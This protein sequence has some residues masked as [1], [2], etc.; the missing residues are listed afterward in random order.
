MN[1]QQVHGTPEPARPGV[2]KLDENVQFTVYR[3]QVVVPEKWYHLLAFAH[4]SERRENAPE[5]N[6]T[7]CR[8]CSGKP[9]KC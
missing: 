5:I 8:K 7:H 4:L 3:P 1:E 9:G 2:K 6:R